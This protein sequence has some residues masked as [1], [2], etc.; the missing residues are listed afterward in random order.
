[1]LVT[2][3][4]GDDPYKIQAIIADKKRSV[5]IMNKKRFLSLLMALAIMLTAVCVT[6]PIESKAYDGWVS[7]ATEAGFNADYAGYLYDVDKYT[8]GTSPEGTEEWFQV[9][10]VTVTKSTTLYATLSSKTEDIIDNLLMSGCIHIYNEKFEI[11]STSEH[12]VVAAATG[13]YWYTAYCDANPGTYYIYYR[14]TVLC[15]D[16]TTLANRIPTSSCTFIFEQRSA[17]AES[18]ANLSKTNIKL[19]KKNITL[20]QGK[21]QTLT[22]TVDPSQELSWSSTNSDVASVD[23][24]GKITAQ[25]IGTAIITAWSRDNRATAS[26]KVTV[27]RPPIIDKVKK[28]TP[29]INSTTV[30]KNSV[31]LKLKN[32]SYATGSGC[33]FQI[34]YRRK[35]TKTWSLLSNK[36]ANSLKVK[37]LRRNTNY[38]F[39]VR[40][41]V[42]VYGTTYFGKWSKT[43]TVKTK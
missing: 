2:H 38:E 13:L 22:A 18:L 3:L 16:K 40:E 6:S 12:D 34:Q 39:Q 24:N 35:G 43:S 17:S 9:Y 37:N 20:V 30:S 42:K 1:M 32:N 25:G 28:T 11:V 33:K 29:K 8:H 21:T 15:R 4:F 19:S 7:Y 10:K 27:K 31:Q 26:C 5:V 23:K 14:P 41:T 36:A